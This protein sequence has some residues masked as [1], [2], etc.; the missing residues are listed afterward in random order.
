MRGDGSG[1]D[2]SGQFQKMKVSPS[3]PSPKICFYKM[4]ATGNDFVVVDNREKAVGD[5]VSFAR[6]VCQRQR[7]VGGDGLLLIETSQRG[8]FKMRIFNA[9]G[10]EAEA[11]GNG[12]RCA[13]LLAH[14][15]L[16]FPKKHRFE[17]LAGIIDAEVKG[18]R[19]R[20]RLMDPKEFK[21]R[22]EMKVNG[23]VLHY[24]FIRVGVPH[25]VVFV[26]GLSKVPVFEIGREIRYHPRFQPA[27]TNVNFVEVT[28]PASIHV[29]TYE[30]GV[31]QNTLACGTGSTASAIVSSIVNGLQAPVRV[32]TRGGEI[33]TVDFTKKGERVQDVYLEGEAKFVFEGKWEI[34]AS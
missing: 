33:L 20:I 23:R 26:E 9:D 16:G 2:R 5:V 13:A 8:D 27:G 19:V 4:V 28:G 29:E 12:F 15:R 22:E 11:C 21:G 30:R 1:G 34:G 18:N 14:E 24:Y 31:E 32:K 10:S 3:E 25:V 17:S 7:G 6:E